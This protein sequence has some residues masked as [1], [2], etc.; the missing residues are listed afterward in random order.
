MRLNCVAAAL[1][2]LAEAFAQT[3]PTPDAILVAGTSPALNRATDAVLTPQSL[4]LAPD[5]TLYL[6]D[7]RHVWRVDAAGA[8]SVVPGPWE[9]APQALSIIT[10]IAAD[11]GGNL[12][13]AEWIQHQIWRVTPQGAITS[14]G[15]LGTQPPDGSGAVPANSV[16]IVATSLAVD[17]QGNIFFSGNTARV[18]KISPDGL[19]RPFAGTGLMGVPQPNAGPVPALQYGLIYPGR[20]ATDR[21]GNVYINDASAVVRVAPDGALRQIRAGGNPIVTSLAV[22]GSGNLYGG[23]GNNGNSAG[24]LARIAPDGTL[25]TFAG[26]GNPGFSDGCTATAPGVPLA[27]QATFNWPSDLAADSAGNLYIADSMNGR[28]RKITRDGQIHTVAGGPGGSFGGD[29]GPA[30]NAFLAGPAALALDSNHN[31]YFIDRNNNRVRRIDP[32]GII[33]T[34]AGSGATAGQDPACTAPSGM[35]LSQPGGLAVDPDG[36]VYIGD[37][38]NHRILKLGADGSLAQIAGTGAAGSGGDGGPAALAQLNAPTGLVFGFGN[39]YIAETDR[40]RYITGDG[41]INTFYAPVFNPTS[42]TLDAAGNVFVANSGGLVELVAGGRVFVL[43]GAGGN[44]L[45]T[46][47]TGEVYSAGAGGAP[48]SRLD[49]DCAVTPLTPFGNDFRGIAVAPGGDL[50]IS[51]ATANRIWRI[52][53]RAP[54]GAVSMSLQPAGIVNGA[55]LRPRSVAV[56]TRVF[57]GIFITVYESENENPAPGE[58]IAI[59]GMC[60][61]PLRFSPGT[62]DSSGRVATTIGDIQ[63]LF[64]GVAAPLLSASPNQLIAVVP[65]EMAGAASAAV[66]VRYHGQRADVPLD[67]AVTSVGIFPVANARYARG[68]TVS[69]SITGGGQT[70]PPGVTGQVAGNPTPQPAAAVQVKVGGVAAEVLAAAADPGTIGV[71]RVTFRIPPGLSPGPTTITVAVG[72]SSDSISAQLN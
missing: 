28:V 15:G 55:T 62:T 17:P 58:I 67:T 1:S 8:L 63:V 43:P 65:Y 16:A 34:V 18:W 59:N 30:A 38:G 12:F 9:P 42:L 52:P 66:Q 33:Q 48:V 29:G 53:G 37:T 32:G 49:S 46:G 19:L 69:L 14:I 24:Q 21:A 23:L 40:I 50:Y 20:L 51:D 36:N 56:Q 7:Q 4:A 13:I 5:G 26:T 35:V 27:I 25:Q 71:T 41:T 11:A 22:D 6:A 39:L 10:A 61:G 60:L 31:L 3:P 57:P 44:A 70:N 2:L 45:A 68:S 47:P 54:G 72:P 64:N